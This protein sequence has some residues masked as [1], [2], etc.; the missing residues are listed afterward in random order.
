[1]AKTMEC[2]KCSGKGYIQGYAHV[3][4]GVCFKC[5]GAGVV[6]YRKP[7][8]TNSSKGGKQTEV[9][10]I[11]DIAYGDPRVWASPRMRVTKEHAWARQHAYEVYV[12]HETYG[13]PE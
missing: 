11:M 13:W 7:R 10:R 8:K 4:S 2:P 3:R 1:M 6:P 9:A 12:Y 5:N